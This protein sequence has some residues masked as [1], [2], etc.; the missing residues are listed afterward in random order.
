MVVVVPAGAQAE[1]HAALHIRGEGVADEQDLLP[2]RITQPL[3]AALK[4]GPAGLGRA[5]LLGDEH[6]LEIS[7]HPRQPQ[8]VGLLLLAGVAGHVEVVCSGEVLQQ[9]RRSVHRDVALVEELGVPPLKGH[10]VG[11]N[12]QLVEDPGEADVVQP[13]PGETALLDLIP[14]PVV[15]VQKH[16]E[17]LRPVG[18]AELP[19][20]RLDGGSG[21]FV[22]I[23]KGIVH[24]QQNDADHTGTSLS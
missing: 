1:V 4:K 13:L 2:R 20:A 10:A 12:A 18:Q 3:H 21:A 23:Q 15:D 5:D 14:Q 7:E 17:H 22:E 11:V 19:E 24:V 6:A 16:R 9:L 8:P